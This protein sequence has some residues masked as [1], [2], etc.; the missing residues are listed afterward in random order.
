MKLFE[1]VFLTFVL[2]TAAVAA[3]YIRGEIQHFFEALF[4][5]DCTEKAV[6]VNCFLLIRWRGAIRIVEQFSVSNWLFREKLIMNNLTQSR[7]EY[8]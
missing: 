8:G 7:K 6:T 2:A 3:G 1:V 4:G 5:L